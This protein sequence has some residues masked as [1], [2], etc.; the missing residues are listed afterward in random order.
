M[1]RIFEFI[2][3]ASQS[4]TTAF[5]VILVIGAAI[6]LTVLVAQRQQNI[7]QKASYCEIQTDPRYCLPDQG[8]KW[9]PF[10][11]DD[12]EYSGPSGYCTT[13]VSPTCVNTVCSNGLGPCRTNSDCGGVDSPGGG[14]GGS[15][16]A[17]W[18]CSGTQ[19]VDNV[20][21]DYQCQS[22]C[23]S[24]W[25]L[26]T[27]SPT[28]CASGQQCCWRN[29][30][31]APASGGGTPAYCS[32]AV[33]AQS[34][35][36]WTNGACQGAI[37]STPTNTAGSSNSKCLSGYRAQ[38]R[39]CPNL[40]QGCNTVPDLSQ[41]IADSTCGTTPPGGAAVSCTA[42]TTTT[43]IGQPITFTATGGDNVNYTWNIPSSSSPTQT[44]KTV[45]ATYQT[46]GTYSA[47]VNSGG[48]QNSCTA[49]TITS[50]GGGCRRRKY[51]HLLFESLQQHSL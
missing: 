48:Q 45:T 11:A 7:Q 17:V 4:R 51:Y 50:G 5:L 42:S 9:T 13:T 19:T 35:G 31:S 49:V 6:P 24:G 39:S 28:T 33:Q 1:K 2:S 12:P 22:S 26:S 27:K 14:G 15:G 25:T 20:P 32:V 29:T 8:C 43:T 18:T 37:I 21:T 16:G 34:C 44:G 23:S 38:Y 47:I 10:F 36:A 46:T 41:C 30:S 3:Q 40:Q